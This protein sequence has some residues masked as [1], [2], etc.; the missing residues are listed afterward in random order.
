MLHHRAVPTN[1]ENGGDNSYT[2]SPWGAQ[3]K[4]LIAPTSTPDVLSKVGLILAL[5]LLWLL[6]NAC[7]VIKSL[8]L[9]TSC[10]KPKYAY[11]ELLKNLAV[12][13]FLIEIILKILLGYFTSS[14][15]IYRCKIFLK[16]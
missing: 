16:R 10:G 1:A 4:Q 11:I 7:L 5:D 15:K 9:G 14:R 3:M 2:R 12:H 13:H 6:W 8:S